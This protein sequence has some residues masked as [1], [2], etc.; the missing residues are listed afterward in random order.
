MQPQ[1]KMSPQLTVIVTNLQLIQL[2][3]IFLVNSVT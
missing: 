3:R 2:P 1:L